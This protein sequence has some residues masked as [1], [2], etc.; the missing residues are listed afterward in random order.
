MRTATITFSVLLALMLAAP[1]TGCG[2]P[3][4]DLP[5]ADV[6]DDREAPPE[7]DEDVEAP[8]EDE[9]AVEE[10]PEAAERVEYALQPA[11]SVIGWVGSS[12]YTGSQRGTFEEFEGILSIEGDDVMT[13]RADVTIDTTSVATGNQTLLEAM[14][15]DVLNVEEFPEAR[16]VSEEVEEDNGSY[17]LVGDFTLHGVTRTIGMP[18][19]VIDVTD[20]AI[21]LEAYF[22][23]SRSNWD[24]YYEGHGWQRTFEGAADNAIRDG[25]AL[26]IDVRAA[27]QD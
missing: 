23:I 3:T 13:L 22:S 15:V 7:D 5:P 24:I 1:L 2:D 6:R 18:L 12:P 16:F 11:D 26:Q 21:R 14:K 17:T 20:D 4:Q 8:A 10:V 9:E 19:D 27:R 25:V